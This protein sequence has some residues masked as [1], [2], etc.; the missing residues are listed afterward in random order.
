M[1][2]TSTSVDLNW[3]PPR[4]PN[5]VL[6]YEIEYST[7]ENFLESQSTTINTASNSTYHRMPDFPEFPRHY[8]KVVAVNSAG[9]GR[10]SSSNIVDVCLGREVGK[11]LLVI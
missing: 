7:N 10:S 3:F 1:R 6:Y 8:F 4:H 11:F 2:S 9:I 5:G